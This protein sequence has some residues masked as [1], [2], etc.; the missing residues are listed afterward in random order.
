MVSVPNPIRLPIWWIGLGLSRVGLV[1][2]HRAKRTVD[3]A[4]PRIVTGI[5]RMSKSAVD[6]AMVGVAVGQAAIAGLGYAAPFWGLAFTLGGGLAAGTIALVSQR[7]GAGTFDQL[8]QA[9]RSSAILVVVVTLPIAVLFWMYPTELISLMTNDLEAIALGGAYLQI[10]A[11]GVPFAALNLVGSRVYIGADDA[12]TPMVIRAGGALTNIGLNAVF[13]FGLDMGVVGAALGTVL[14]NVAVTALFGIGLVRGGLPGGVS[15]PIE[16]NPRGKYI[17][18]ETFT[19]LI[20]IGTPVIGRGAVWT[21]AAF[22]ML[23]ILALFGQHVVAAYVI[24][25]SIWDLM[26]AP[27]W[28]FGIAASSLV[29][30]SLG[31]GE[32]S[33]AEA[34]G[35]EITRIA[36]VSYLAGAIVVL[37]LAE[38]I[39][40]LFVDDPGAASVP[41]AIGLTQAAAL[42]VVANA[43]A[44]TYA[45]ALD[46][47]GDT[48]WP[49]YSGA[50]GMI[51]LA[52]PLAYLGAVTPLGIWGIYLAYFVQTIVPAIINRRRF[53]TGKWKQISRQYR[54]ET[55]S[56]GD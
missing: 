7:F 42:A 43:L 4:W 8:G 47:T 12:W 23:A 25:R 51:G 15:V 19:D 18:F 20:R 30:Q 3:L 41:I 45:G 27:G 38:P 55:P 22:G 56:P 34:Y 14:A 36:V 46:A 16:I 33:V 52:L 10:L 48:K 54:P 6:I 5:A 31:E 37:A 40:H 17:D 32:E 24:S 11:L 9:V 1:D 21:G 53:T 35:Y 44:G 29:G 28:G 2:K 26:N 49:F 13:I 39:V 50:L